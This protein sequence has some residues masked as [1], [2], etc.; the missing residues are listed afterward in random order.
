MLIS[1]IFV[2]R[3][4][5]SFNFDMNINCFDSQSFGFLKAFAKYLFTLYVMK[6]WLVIRNVVQ[7]WTIGPDCTRNLCPSVRISQRTARLAG[8][9]GVPYTMTTRRT[10]PWICGPDLNVLR[11]IAGANLWMSLSPIGRMLFHIHMRM[12]WIPMVRSPQLHRSPT[13]PITRVVKT[14]QNLP[15]P[16]ASMIIF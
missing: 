4:V 5:V 1:C 2:F 13:Q 6:L 9:N 10:R 3:E 14:H 8:R 15:S 11:N 12:Q 16:S 7:V